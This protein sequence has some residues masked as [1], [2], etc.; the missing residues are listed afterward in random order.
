MKILLVKT[1]SLGDIIQAFPVISFVEKYPGAEI[2]W[3]VEK[4]F[5]E[6]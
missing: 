4:S 2:D 6:I 5:R 3:V 1:S